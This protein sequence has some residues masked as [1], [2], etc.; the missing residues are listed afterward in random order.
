MRPEKTWFL[1]PS[2]NYSPDGPIVLGALLLDPFM[3]DQVL[4]EG[5]II[6]PKPEDVQTMSMN[7]WE[8]VIKDKEGLKPG[9]LGLKPGLFTEFLSFFRK[10]DKS[11]VA[12]WSSATSSVYRAKKMETIQFSPSLKYLTDTMATLVVSSYLLQKRMRKNVY[13][14]TGVRIAHGVSVKSDYDAQV[15]IPDMSIVVGGVPAGVPVRL[16]PSLSAHGSR[17]QFETESSFVFAYRLRKVFYNRKSQSILG[18]V[19]GKGALLFD[20]GPEEDNETVEVLG[21]EDEDT[22]ADEFGLKF[23]ESLGDNGLQTERFIIRD[24][25]EDESDSYM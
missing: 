2:L 21:L 3:P 24:T 22:G 25:E 9:L 7:D 16:G 4:N 23:K 11:G 15:S 18:E 8:S 20:D 13:L 5:S 1:A 12:K 6:P 10:G 14:V 17:M 19:Y